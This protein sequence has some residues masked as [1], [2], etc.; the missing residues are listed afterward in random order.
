[1]NNNVYINEFMQGCKSVSNI[2]HT[3]VYY[4]YYYYSGVYLLYY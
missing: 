4:Y 1:M 3:T 2:T